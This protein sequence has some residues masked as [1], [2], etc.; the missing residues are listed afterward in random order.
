MKKKLIILGAVFGIVVSSSIFLSSCGTGGE[1]GTVSS[2][3]SNVSF[4][5]TDKPERNIEEVN[6]TI[7]KVEFKHTGR[8]NECVLFEYDP[9]SGEPNPLESVNVLELED[10]YLFVNET[11]CEKAPYNRLRIEFDREVTVKKDGQLYT[12][13]VEGFDRGNGKQPN[14]PHCV[15]E[16]CYIEMNG[17]VNIAAN[18][19][20][21]GVDFDI[22][23]SKIIIDNTGNCSIVF[24]LTPLHIDKEKFKAKKFK[25]KGFIT[26]LDTQNKEFTLHHGKREFTVDYSQVI[27]DNID[28]ILNFAE[29][30]NF[31]RRVVVDVKCFDFEKEIMTCDAEKIDLILRAVQVENLDDVNKTF[32]V[33]LSNGQVITIDYSNADVDEDL[34]NGDYVRVKIE[35]ATYNET[36]GTY[37]YNAK[38]VKV[39]DM[40]EDHDMDNDTDHDSDMDNDSN[41]T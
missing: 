27:Q 8:G 7:N 1:E 3:S 9:N 16:S 18:V 40:D 20:N 25:T 17:A 41:Q 38:K 15:G 6:V 31:D 34:E 2:T 21:V 35:T 19:E 36:D 13:V 22:K 28:Q 5:L 29:E 4:Y 23:K 32:Q 33:S 24:K 37:I 30:N 26:D 12:C 10:S 39:L 14:R 11:E